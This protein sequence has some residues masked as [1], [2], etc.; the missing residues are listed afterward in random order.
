MSYSQYPQ[1]SSTETTKQSVSSTTTSS[2]KKDNRSIIYGV[3]I[4]ALLGSW[5]YIIYSQNKTKEEIANLTG[6]FSSVDSTKNE[7]QE[8]FNLVSLKLDSLTG[9]NTQLQGALAE[10]NA[11]LQKQKNEIAT[12]LKKNNLSANEKAS[13]RNKI[14]NLNGQV[15][16]YIAEIEKLK[17]ENEVLT[18]ANTG[19]TAER[20]TLITQKSSLEQN[21]TAADNERRR[22]EE[23]ASTLRASNINITAINVKGGG[24]E[25]E[26]TTAKRADLMRVSFDIVENKVAPSGNKD[27][28]VIV[29]APDGTPITTGS[30]F[31]TKDEGDKS[32]TSKVDVNYQQGKRL[33]VSF[34]WKG[35]AKYMTGN[36]KIQIYHNGEKIGEGSKSLKKGGLFG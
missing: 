21:L 20:D 30:T 23:L 24:K 28:Y 35:D 32:F 14:A 19:L 12:L 13:L 26:T 22:V 31:T 2:P 1:G 33:P 8:E 25:K 29:T 9:T 4:A 3:L 15:Q 7:L 34:D 17:G 5:G 6:Q 16:N 11:D 36:Y 10:R 27:F 18:V